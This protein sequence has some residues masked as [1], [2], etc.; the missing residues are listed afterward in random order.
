MNNKIFAMFLLIGGLVLL[1]VGVAIA[2]SSMNQAIESPFITNVN[3]TW[4]TEAVA[5]LL[6]AIGA[7]LIL[8]GILILFRS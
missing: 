6:A 4:N 3:S 1:L 7:I 2:I 8:F 5:I